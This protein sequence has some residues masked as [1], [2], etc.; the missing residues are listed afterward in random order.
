MRS[1]RR[2]FLLTITIIFIVVTYLPLTKP[3]A[4]DKRNIN[5]IFQGN[6]QAELNTAKNLSYEY[7]TNH[8]RTYG[9]DT[10]QDLKVTNVF[11]YNPS[12]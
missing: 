11:I 7:L 1:Y 5:K 9:I 4:D 12:C 6:S 2:L 10:V 3:S 8:T